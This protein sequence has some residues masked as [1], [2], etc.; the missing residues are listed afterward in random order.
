MTTKAPQASTTPTQDTPILKRPWLLLLGLVL[1]ALNLR[2]ALS[3]VAPLLNAVSDSLGLS[4]AR[5]GLLTTLPVLCL[6]L[7]A[8]LAP[9]LA[10]RFGSERV[11]LGI[12]LVL[13]AGIL[14]RSH[15][16]EVG[17]FAGSLLAGASIGIIGVLLPGIVKRDFPRQAGAMTGVYTMALC[18]G[19]AI[20][21][22]LTVPLTQYFDNRWSVGLG[23]WMIPAVLAALVWLPQARELHAHHQVAYRVRGLLRDPL[24]WQVTLY[25]G[26]QSSLAYIVFGWLPSVLIDRGMTPTQAGLLL[27]GSI[28]VQLI[29][30]L[31]APW[32]ATRGKDQRLAIVLVMLLTLAG[33]FGCLYAPLEGLWGWAI[34]LGLGQGGTFS[35]ALA[36]IVLRS[37]DS[38]VASNLSG[39]AQ[40]I[41]YTIASTGPLAVGV[42]HD[43]TGSWDS[44]GWIF[45]ALGLG[46]IVAGLGAGR[47]LYVQVVSEKV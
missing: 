24:A 29:S 3:S 47:A 8:P 10:R 31:S 22:G 27:S 14:L 12:L 15:F 44:I 41:G 26:L 11:V 30:A 21:A 9:R 16:G 38:H 2:P 17:L 25:M 20:A 35:L 1:V 46:A 43:V 4:A 19:A 40:G 7:F 18:L 5:A 6:G 33:L 34:L 36:L 28:I 13:A 23:F 42:V 39:M 32:L 45:A 37:R